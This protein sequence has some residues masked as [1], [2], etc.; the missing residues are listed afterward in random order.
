MYLKLCPKKRPNLIT[1]YVEKLK[2][3]NKFDPKKV[4]KIIIKNR[5]NIVSM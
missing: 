2:C 1:Y 5:I 3:I 4:K